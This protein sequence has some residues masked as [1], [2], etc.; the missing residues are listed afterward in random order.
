MPKL[1][2]LVFFLT[3]FVLLRLVFWWVAFPNPDEAYYWLW[4]QHPALS[5]YDHPPLLAWVN[6]LFDA[7]LG[8]SSFTLRLPNLLVNGALFY[9]YYQI[10]HYLYGKSA[11]K[12][13]WLILLSVLAAPLYYMFLALAWSDYLMITLNLAAAF[14][15]VTF[16]DAYKTAQSP[17]PY[18]RL[19]LAA[20]AI[21]LA[22]LCKYNTVLMAIGFLAVLCTDKSLRSLWRNHHL[23]IAFLIAIVALLP[24]LLWNIGNDFQSFRYYL[25]RS[26]DGSGS[27]FKVGESLGFLLLSIV[28]LSPITCFAML[29][30]LKQPPQVMR[31][32]SV[33][34]SL[35][36]WV[37]A[38]STGILALTAL[39]ST[40]LYYWNINA[41]LLLFPLLPAF[42][43]NQEGQFIRRG[44][45][46][47][48]QIYGLLFAIFFMVHYSLLPVSVWSGPDADPDTR[49]MFGWQTVATEVR[50]TAETL[51]NNPFLL[52][53][54]Y[55]SGSAL[56]YQLNQ[57]EVTV[58]ADR[59]S[60]F[61]FWYDKSTLQG[62]NAVIVSDDWHP[63][64][65][66]LLAQFDRTST[67]MTVPAK[68]FGFWVK[69]YYITQG[70]NFR[71]R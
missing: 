23:Y 69:N 51:G 47:G 59:I 12:Y 40:A 43:I 66:A 50:Q 32:H 36:F 35:A 62:R 53:T 42:F 54:D 22:L 7:V 67:P 64:E 41:Y 33:Y 28:M 68:R 46:W 15:F 45:F 8:R 19:Y 55:R 16:G 17:I 25:Y 27:Y 44:W 31:S 63:L 21:G 30:G 34:R 4:G 24:I 14:W 9:T 26:G 18:W 71:G 10:T 38:L 13:F 2:G 11:K 58:I 56:A 1:A 39:V 48:G 6:G 70:Y 60:Q 3:T 37:F 65:P 61:T 29:A 52:T 57:K 5:Y 20:G 49:M